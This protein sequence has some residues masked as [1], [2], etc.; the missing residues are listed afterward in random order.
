MWKCSK[1]STTNRDDDAAICSSC[2]KQ[3]PARN[4][5]DPSTPEHQYLGR[6][7]CPSCGYSNG[8]GRETHCYRCKAKLRPG[9]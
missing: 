8:S 2:R 4:S 3:N 9:R 1:C 7:T 5:R 6:V